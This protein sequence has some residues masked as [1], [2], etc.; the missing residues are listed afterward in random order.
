MRVS[1]SL[2]GIKKL[3][4]LTNTGLGTAGCVQ[5]EKRWRKES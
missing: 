3:R 2:D 5:K 1:T 4:R